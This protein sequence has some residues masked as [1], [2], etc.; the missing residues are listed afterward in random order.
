MDSYF[1]Q[2][3]EPLDT[4]FCLFSNSSR[5]WLFNYLVTSRLNL[6]ALRFNKFLGTPFQARLLTALKN[7]HQNFVP[8]F[9]FPKNVE[10]NS[11]GRNIVLTKEI[12]TKIVG[13]LKKWLE[14][15]FVV[16]AVLYLKVLH[17]TSHFC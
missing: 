5:S 10:E 6:T 11:S 15:E 4:L 14:V 1:Q 8:T 3:K 16:M 9:L 12:Y 13:F 2:P 7:F 17:E